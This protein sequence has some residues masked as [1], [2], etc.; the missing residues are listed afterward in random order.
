[1]YGRRCGASRA[2]RDGRENAGMSN[3]KM[4]GIPIRRKPK[5]SRVKVI[6]HSG[7]TVVPVQALRCR[8]EQANPLS[9]PRR[10]CE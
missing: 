9:E 8:G 2:G 3:V 7:A 1:M 6:K 10:E 5:V 4:G